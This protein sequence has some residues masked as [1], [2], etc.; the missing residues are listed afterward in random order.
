[1]LYQIKI[2]P[3]VISLN[4]GNTFMVSGMDG[5]RTGTSLYL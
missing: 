5:E 3:S 2:G 4:Q 1:M